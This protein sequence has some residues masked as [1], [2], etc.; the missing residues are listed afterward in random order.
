MRWILLFLLLT[1]CLLSAQDGNYALGARNGAMAGTSL[2]FTDGW[3][4]FNNPG[5]LG[6]LEASTAMI[7]Y[8]NRYNIEGFHVLGGGLV[9]HHS[10]VNT[11]IKYYKFGDDLFN[12]QVIG[13]VL[14]NRIQMVSLGAG[15]NIIQTHAEGLSTRRVAALEMGGTAEI[16]RQIIF[17]AHIFN[18]KHG[19]MHPTT[20]KAGLSFRPKDFLM[21]NTEVEKQLDSREKF[22]AGLE[23]AIIKNVLIRTGLNVQGNDLSNSQVRATFGFGF[24]PKN[25]LF[26]YAFSNEN[27]GAIHEI[28]LA[29]QLKKP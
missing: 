13:L 21:I 10:L 3:A 4:A 24:Q 11:A 17:G 8:Q 16:T 20:M 2:T 25:F 5:A 27:L 1:P 29:Y 6:G 9:Y 14:A 28:S 7:T 12:Q 22:K 18:F 26:D 15:I 19:T 23:Y